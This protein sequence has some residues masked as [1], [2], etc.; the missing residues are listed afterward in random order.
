MA[1]FHVLQGNLEPPT[2]NRIY[3]EGMYDTIFLFTIHNHHLKKIIVFYLHVNFL[4]GYNSTDCFVLFLVILV[5]SVKMSKMDDSVKGGL[6][7]FRK[8]LQ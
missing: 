5:T 7:Q 6:T 1:D 3:P 2:S 4:W 8:F